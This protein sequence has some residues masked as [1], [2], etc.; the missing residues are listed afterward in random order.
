MLYG[1]ILLLIIY[2]KKVLENEEYNW[3]YVNWFYV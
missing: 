3:F 1:N 2:V